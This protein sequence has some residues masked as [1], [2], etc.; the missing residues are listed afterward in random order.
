VINFVKLHMGE[1]SMI[2]GTAAVS[3]W[4]PHWQSNDE[5]CPLI[6]YWMYLNFAVVLSNNLVANR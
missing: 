2:G 1:Q 4:C 5:L 3:S 6:R